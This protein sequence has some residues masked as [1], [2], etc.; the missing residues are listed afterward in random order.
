MTT[1]HSSSSYQSTLSDYQHILKICSAGVK[2]PAILPAAAME[3]LYS[4]KPDVTDLHSIT[5][6]H[7]IKA[8][9]ERAKL[10]S[11]ILILSLRKSTS[12]PL[13]N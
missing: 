9:M 5:P 7:Y 12:T 2:I 6:R 1:I 10:F 8:G 3:L 4:L 13:K 11:P